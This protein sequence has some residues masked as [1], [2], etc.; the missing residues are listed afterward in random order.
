L[1]PNGPVIMCHGVS[2]HTRQNKNSTVN[3]STCNKSNHTPSARTNA[4]SPCSHK[5]R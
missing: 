4:T 5:A 1:T 2:I 3:T